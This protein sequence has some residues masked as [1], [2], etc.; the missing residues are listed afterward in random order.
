M[1]DRPQRTVSEAEVRDLVTRVVDG[2]LNL[3]A[4][5]EPDGDEPMPGVAHERIAIGADHGG[6]A[7]KE[8]IGFRLREAGHDVDD[9]G[10]GSAEPAVLYAPKV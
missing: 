10:T 3:E 2:I 5:H 7:L 9:C 8:R 4:D 6:Y 1:A